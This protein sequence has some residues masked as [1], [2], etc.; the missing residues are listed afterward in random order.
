MLIKPLACF[1][2]NGIVLTPCYEE[3]YAWVFYHLSYNPVTPNFPGSSAASTQELNF[4]A[5]KLTH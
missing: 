5:H 1:Y 4:F 2:N 3:R